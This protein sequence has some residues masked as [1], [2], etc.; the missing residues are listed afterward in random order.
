M[1]KVPLFEA[2]NRLTTLIHEAEEG[3]P[4][5]LT[6][7][8]K[9]AAVLLGSSD[10]ANLVGRQRKFAACLDQFRREW[11]VGLSTEY[12]DPFADIRSLEGGRRVDI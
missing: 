10:Y 9:A 5:Q 2:R 4:V 12:Q 6:R 8:G 7:H 3:S 11:P 1:R